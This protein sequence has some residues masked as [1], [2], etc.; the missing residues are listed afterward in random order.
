MKFFPVFLVLGIFCLLPPWVII[1]PKKLIRW[2]T[3]GND[4]GQGL[5]RSWEESGEDAAGK[6]IHAK[7]QEV[8]PFGAG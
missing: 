3:A 5:C 6:G 2:E 1:L 8:A 7:Q 4:L